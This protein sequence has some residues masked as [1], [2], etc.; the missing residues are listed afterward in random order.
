MLLAMRVHDVLVCE[1]A[2]ER[3][4]ELKLFLFVSSE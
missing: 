2:P 1:R 4:F 3:S